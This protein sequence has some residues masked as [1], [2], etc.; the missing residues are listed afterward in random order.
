[1]TL[2]TGI[3][4][5]HYDVDTSLL[6]GSETALIRIM[7][8][9]GMHTVADQSDEVFKVAGKPPQVSITWPGENSWSSPDDM[10]FARIPA[11]HQAQTFRDGVDVIIYSVRLIARERRDEWL[12]QQQGKFPQSDPS[13]EPG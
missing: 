6:A 1:M 10:L 11:T 12:P 5:K 3:E 9:D 4:E 13:G 2:V 7:V 8:S